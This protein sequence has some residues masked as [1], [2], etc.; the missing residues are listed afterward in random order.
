MNERKLF[1]EERYNASDCSTNIVE[2]KKRKF[3]FLDLLWCHIIS[4]I[5]V[6]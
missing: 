3:C 6:A 5:V 1:Q 2:N 4:N